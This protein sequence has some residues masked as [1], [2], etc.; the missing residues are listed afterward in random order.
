MEREESD[1]ACDLK[2]LLHNM[3]ASQRS[4]A[5]SLSGPGIT[6]QSRGMLWEDWSIRG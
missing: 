5:T 4:G 1:I 2:S 3:Q 6:V